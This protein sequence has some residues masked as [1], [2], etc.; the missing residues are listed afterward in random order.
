MK[1]M[2]QAVLV[3]AMAGTA[4][5]ANAPA[6]S[7][8]APPKYVPPGGKVTIQYQLPRLTNPAACGQPPTIQF[9]IK[10]A[11]GASVGQL[12]GTS[13]PVAGKIPELTWSTATPGDYYLYGTFPRPP[14]PVVDPT[15]IGVFPPYPVAAG[16][17]IGVNYYPGTI[18]SWTGYGF[19][20]TEIGKPAKQINSFKFPAGFGTPPTP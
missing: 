9:E 3:T 10:N 14:C 13:Y 16:Q 7:A 20:A 6:S 4:L 11:S 8:V 5:L 17:S 18:T 15:P 2:L 19:M 1:R 12:T